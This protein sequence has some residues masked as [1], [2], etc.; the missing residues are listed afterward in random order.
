[1]TLRPGDFPSTNVVTAPE[2]Q[3]TADLT[4][5]E[6]AGSLGNLA[7]KEGF[8]PSLLRVKELATRFSTPVPD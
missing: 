2:R 7:E 8:S 4:T 6:I 5:S 3:G 1:M